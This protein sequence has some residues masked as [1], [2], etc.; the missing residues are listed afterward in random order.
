MSIE[1]TP[2]EEMCNEC[3]DGRCEECPIFDLDEE[4]FL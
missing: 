1:F 2:Y 3:T 4:E